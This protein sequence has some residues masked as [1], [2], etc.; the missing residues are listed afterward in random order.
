MNTNWPKVQLGEVL[1]QRMPDAT[2]DPTETYNFAGVY[3]FA[4][5]VFRGQARLGSEFSYRRLTRLRKGEFVF[6]KLMAWE[7]GFGI[8]PEECDG[9]YVSPEFP[10][11]EINRDRLIPLFLG[12]Y[13]R[14]PE[15]WASMSGG[16]TGTNV[17]RRRLHPKDFLLR[18]I[19]L[20]P[21]AT[22]RQVVARI[23]E[24]NT[25]IQDARSLRE[26]ATR[27]TA[28][29]W[30]RGAAA[31]F[32]RFTKL[33]PLRRLGEVVAVRGGGTPMKSD[34][35]YWDGS[36]PWIT[37]KDMKVREVR[38]SIDHVS[39]RAVRE[40]SAK[41][42]NPGAVLVVVRGMILA[43]TLPSAMLAVPAAINQDMKALVPN[44][45][46]LSDFLCALLWAFNSKYLSLVEK[47]THDTRKLET[48]R[49]LGSVIPVPSILDQRRIVAEVNGLQTQVDTLKRLQ[50][51]A[52]KE[53][54]VLS[55]SVLER[56]L[57]G[58]L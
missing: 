4:R 10:V 35:L 27:Q 7:G 14:I 57:K 55:R 23:E 48:A 16:S 50:A 51:D 45:T 5:G 11:F 40:T 44:A 29:L 56:A 2:V 15:V 3:S 58:E 47:S 6:P 1:R 54:D 41:V 53:L 36:I 38:D 33:C 49:L 9:C 43:H 26:K 18:E 37:P 31:I 42:I 46:L 28:S 13:F 34:P 19:P 52:A 21:L 25:Q 17:R 12:F 32:E 39:E 20:P 8:V 30:A 24:L 22:Q